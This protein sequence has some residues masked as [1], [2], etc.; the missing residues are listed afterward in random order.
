MCKLTQMILID[1]IV[2]RLTQA[3]KFYTN[4]YDE[5][6]KADELCDLKEL[7]RLRLSLDQQV[8]S[9]KPLIAKIDSVI[10]EPPNLC[11]NWTAITLTTGK[12][13]FLIACLITSLQP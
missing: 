10:N 12:I 8:F 2:I 5:I 9:F 4:E 3:I 11:P 1:S 13:A 6:V 7:D